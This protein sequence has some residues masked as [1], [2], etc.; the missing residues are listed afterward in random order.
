MHAYIELQ[1]VNSIPLIVYI[2]WN[3]VIGETIYMY[4]FINSL[5]FLDI[6]HLVDNMTGEIE[7]FMNL[8]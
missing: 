2:S 6:V 8:N 7:R 1:N 4:F 5:F 3:M